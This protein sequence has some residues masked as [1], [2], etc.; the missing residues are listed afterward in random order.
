MGQR[1]K[2]RRDAGLPRGPAGHHVDAGQEVREALLLTGR[3]GHD[4]GHVRKRRAEGLQRVG[5]H[6]TSAQ[7]GEDFGRVAPE[8]GRRARGGEH[9]ADHGR[10]HTASPR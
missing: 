1:A 6:G 10:E 2:T 4:H 3:N 5:D 8:A 7:V 9:E